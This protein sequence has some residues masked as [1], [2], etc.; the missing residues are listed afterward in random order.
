MKILLMIILLVGTSG[1]LPL[2]ANNAIGGS[3]D[4]TKQWISG[5]QLQEQKKFLLAILE[6][7]RLLHQFPTYSS[8]NLVYLRIGQCYD[9]IGQPAQA[10]R[11]YEEALHATPQ[12][13]PL[14][15]WLML[16]NAK[17]RILQGKF[18][19][20]LTELYSLDTLNLG[21]EMVDLYHLLAA[22]AL[23]H[24][25]S[26]DQ[27]KHHL[28]Q[29]DV[30][31]EQLK[32]YDRAISASQRPNPNAAMIMSAILPGAG[33]LYAGS[34]QEALNSF[35]I[36][37]FFLAVTLRTAQFVRVFDVVVAVLPWFQRYYVGGYNR[38]SVL[39][40]QKQMKKRDASLN[41]VLKEIPKNRMPP[42]YFRASKLNP[43]SMN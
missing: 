6:Y 2:L 10:Q 12:A 3:T 15:Q 40:F 41:N 13:D 20:A 17:N 8:K 11:Y 31:Q 32:K 39:A 21:E 29:L 33:Q 16:L 7:N 5:H 22:V 43:N 26:S 1:Q 38:A 19:P 42:D 4:T 37:A 18:A 24:L 34:K 9:S 23:H 27:C 36:N 30:D 25:G 35:A 28:S 14:V